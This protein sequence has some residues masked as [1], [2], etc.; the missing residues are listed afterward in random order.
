VVASGR[1]QEHGKMPLQTKGVKVYAEHVKGL[2]LILNGQEV[3][4]GSFGCVRE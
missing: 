1:L 3:L 2:W 4:F